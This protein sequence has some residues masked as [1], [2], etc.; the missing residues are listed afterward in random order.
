MKTVIHINQH[1]IRRNQKTGL[2]DPVISVKTY[3]DNRYAKKV[4]ILD[5]DGAVVATIIYS[6]DK[7][8]NCGARCWVETH[9]NVVIE[10]TGS[11]A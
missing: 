8:L 5:K 6:P 1:I 9:N 11:V 3:K 10:S 4:S 7:P 2:R